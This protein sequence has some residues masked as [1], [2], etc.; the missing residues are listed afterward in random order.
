MI[1]MTDIELRTGATRYGI[2]DIHIYEPGSERPFGSVESG[3]LLLED[4]RLREEISPLL[5][6][7]GITFAAPV[8]EYPMRVQ[9]QFR[10]AAD[11]VPNLSIYYQPGYIKFEMAEGTEDGMPLELAEYN[12][13]TQKLW[14]EDKAIAPGVCRFAARVGIPVKS[15]GAPKNPWRLED[16]V[17]FTERRDVTKKNR[18]FL[19]DMK[20]LVLRREIGTRILTTI[21][22]KQ[23]TRWLQQEQTPYRLKESREEFLVREEFVQQRQQLFGTHTLRQ[24][25]APCRLCGHDATPFRFRYCQ[26]ELAYCQ[27]CLDAARHGRFAQNRA[28]AIEV[29]KELAKLEFAGAPP[30]AV[31]LRKINVLGG[32]NRTPEEIDQMVLLRFFIK[33]GEWPW[34][35]L[36]ADAGMIN[37]GLRTSRGTA[38][39]ALDGHLCRS[40]HEKAVDDF[41]HQHGI[42]HEQEPH[43]PHDLVLNPNTRRRADWVLADGTFVEMWGL[44]GDTA[45]DEKTEEKLVLAKKNGLRL[46][47]LKR[48]DVQKLP[49]IF[50]EWMA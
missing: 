6:G 27:D 28:Q 1:D 37:D 4:E 22:G 47:G 20:E 24:A 19:R 36:L 32:F 5:R 39:P 50:R 38:I 17:H 16:E 43:Y 46:V 18:P 34:M 21:L 41:F 26:V 44:H 29:V 42:A 10:L 45:Y 7:Q 14:V 2:R 49:E 9:K 23:K 33:P 3:W 40:L 48:S 12:R 15:V 31:Q 30:L 11:E 35:K 25:I 13:T 8:P